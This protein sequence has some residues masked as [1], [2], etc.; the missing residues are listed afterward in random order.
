[1]DADVLCSVVSESTDPQFQKVVDELQIIFLEV[2]VF[3]IDV[4]KISHSHKRALIAVVVV[5]YR[6]Q[7]F[8]MEHFVASANGFIEIIG[9]GI[10]IESG[11]VGENVDYYPYIV[12]CGRVH[13]LFHLLARTYYV[14]ADF[15]IGRLIVVIPVSLF[16]IVV[17]NQFSA[18]L[19]SVAILH[20]R[21][22]HHRESC[23]GNF[24][25][26]LADGREVPAPSMEDGF[27]VCGLG[28]V[29]HTVFCRKRHDRGEAESQCK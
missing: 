6:S 15:P 14:V 26:I 20:R 22:L 23:V 2:R 12:F 4:R 11:V 18:S 10:N 1:M 8:G 25:H 21:R 27:G 13:H 5:F 7:S 28:V 9:D 19:G 17:E 29:S 3:G 16:D 24:F